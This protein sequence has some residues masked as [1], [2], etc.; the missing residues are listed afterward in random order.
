M[1]TRYRSI[2]SG[3]MENKTQE[4]IRHYSGQVNDLPWQSGEL[5]CST[6]STDSLQE[7]IERLTMQ[8]IE[9]EMQK[10][11]LQ[12]VQEELQESRDKFQELYDNC[13]VGYLTIDINGIITEANLTIASVLGEERQS[14]IGSS[15][16]Q[17]IPADEKDTIVAY[18]KQQFETGNRSSCEVKMVQ[19]EGVQF[20]AH[21]DG[22]LVRKKDTGANLCRITVTDITE[23][24]IMEDILKQSKEEL[25]LKVRERTLELETANARLADELLEHKRTEDMLKESNEFN[26]ALLENSPNPILLF[27]TDTSVKYVNPAFEKLTGYSKEETLGIRSP[28]P[29]WP[30]E[31]ANQ[32]EDSNAQVR[33][34]GSGRIER[35]Y[36]KKNGELFWVVT[37]ITSIKDKTSDKIKYYLANWLDITELKQ[38][39][40]SI[41][42][43]A[44]YDNVT[45]LPNRI[46]LFDRIKMAIVQ[47]NRN[48]KKLALIMFDL[49]NFKAVNDTLGH[50]HGDL[51]LK[52]VGERISAVLRESDTVARTGGDEFMILLPEVTSCEDTFVVANKILDIF[53]IPFDIEGNS[54]RVTASIGIACF[55]EAGKDLNTLSKNAD[56]AMYHAKHAGKNRCEIFRPQM[57]GT[58]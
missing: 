43:L 23:H 20:Y 7:L 56:T 58:S 25:E 11:A 51:L 37:S 53:Q 32:Y 44:Y 21:L 52:K 16:L 2:R 1:T 30:D 14:L 41:K 39:Q 57:T 49:D 5:D 46:L 6:R 24:K 19:K 31:L 55:P 3:K 9:L 42:Q 54:C 15:L 47:A 33:G 29:W 13:P 28:Y 4:K 17:Y 48:H 10:G 38:A 27:D 40:E 50:A 18:I 8:Q 36:R 26:T 35:C 45:G 34:I 22:M 12:R